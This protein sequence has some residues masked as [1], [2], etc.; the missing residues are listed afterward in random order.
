MNARQNLTSFI[1]FSAYFR[2]PGV[3]RHRA[4]LGV[5]HQEWQFAGADN[6]ETAGL[7]ARD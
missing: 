6:R 7:I 1:S 4:A 3:E 5:G 2:I